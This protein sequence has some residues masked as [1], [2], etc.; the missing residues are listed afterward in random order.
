MSKNM[1]AL[2]RINI[3]CS[4]INK[5]NPFSLEYSIRSNAMLSL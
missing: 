2:M 4:L 1:S 5:V 3:S